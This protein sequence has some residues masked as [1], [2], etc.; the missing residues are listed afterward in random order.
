MKALAIVL[1]DKDGLGADI[2]Y[3]PVPR[4]AEEF[5]VETLA[6]LEYLDRE[7]GRLLLHPIKL[8]VATQ[9]ARA[10][11]LG[12]PFAEDVEAVID[13]MR[14]VSHIFTLHPS[15]VLEIRDTDVPIRVDTVV[16]YV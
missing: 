10:G 2:Y 7:A 9:D 4:E 6:P 16:G 12:I 13:V 8:W 14:Q 1:H 5:L 3:M 15:A 11:S